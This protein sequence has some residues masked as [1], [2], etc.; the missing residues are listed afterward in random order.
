MER[1]I[2][3]AD[4]SPLREAVEG[5]ETFARQQNKKIIDLCYKI[6]DYEREKMVIGTPTPEEKHHF[7]NALNY[8]LNSLQ[9]MAKL[10]RGADPRVIDSSELEWLATRL[11]MSKDTFENPMTTTEADEF[12]AK[13]FPG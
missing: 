5:I 10:S 11:K 3:R 8:L 13:H 9:F 6:L 12:L 4:S 2:S 1:A 7:L